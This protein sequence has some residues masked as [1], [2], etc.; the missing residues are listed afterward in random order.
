MDLQQ[1]IITIAVIILAILIGHGLWSARK[2]K[3]QRE[4]ANK[5]FE[6]QEP[7]LATE[8]VSAPRPVRRASINDQLEVQKNC[9][10]T[11]TTSTIS[12]NTTKPTTAPVTEITENKDDV[13]VHQPL[14][15]TLD[16]DDDN[17]EQE[18]SQIKI[19]LPGQPPISA[20]SQSNPTLDAVKGE[21]EITPSEQTTEITNQAKQNE[22]DEIKSVNNSE[23]S[24][25]KP[26]TTEEKTQ[27][28]YLVIYVVAPENREFYGSR[29]VASLENL[30]FIFGQHNIFHYH[31]DLN[32]DSPITFS[33]AN[34]RKPGV[35][36]LSNMDQFST[37]GL[38]FFM[39]L[40]SPGNNLVNFRTMLRTATTLSEELNGFLLN[41]R[42]EIFTEENK[43]AYLAKVTEE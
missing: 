13:A 23:N 5:R 18:V 7:E 26:E 38:T 22:K 12:A 32:A 37:N 29:I 28:E 8:Y 40:P 2:E 24:A 9:V 4:Q 31:L 34:M 21:Q 17:L 6:R 43:Q 36:D 11:N 15:Q 27:Q 1:I 14:Q 35:F 41:D 16:L 20:T 30:G 19:T 3:L 10:N 42:R 33:V 25:E 39:P